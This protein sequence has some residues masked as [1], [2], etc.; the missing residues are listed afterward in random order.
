MDINEFISIFKKKYKKKS[1]LKD[2]VN[3]LKSIKF[4]NWEKFIK[5][6]EK[7]YFR[8]ILFRN[9]DFEIIVITW[10]NSQKTPIHSHPENGCIM[11]IL[12]GHLSE[13]KHYPNKNIESFIY[14]KG[15]CSYIHNDIATHVIENI[16]GDVSVS[17]HIYSPPNFYN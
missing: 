10:M 17:L 13:K 8:N 16:S 14:H 1:K 12:K 5:K 15:D 2:Y 9:D 3:L 7:K 11:K 4:Q 6:D